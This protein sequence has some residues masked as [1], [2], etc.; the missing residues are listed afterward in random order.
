MPGQNAVYELPLPPAR[1]FIPTEGDQG[2]AQ[3]VLE[4]ILLKN[5]L[6][7]CR[8]RWII[9][10][11]FAA[12]GI[13]T[14]LPGLP[15]LLGFTERV[16]WPFV[17]AATLALGNLAFLAHIGSLVGKAGRNVGRRNLWTQIIFDLIIITVS[18]HLVGS[19][20]THVSFIYLFHVVLSCIFLSRFE[21]F[22]ITMI[23][24]GFF[25][26][27]VVLETLG[28]FPAKSIFADTSV[29]N[30]MA[31]TNLPTLN[32]IS[33]GMILCVVWYL[34]SYLSQMVRQREEDLEKTNELL[35]KAQEERMRFM[36]HTTHE[37]KAP[38]AAIQAN[39][40]LLMKGYCGPLPMDAQDAMERIVNRSRRLAGMIQEMLQLA[41][42]R[43]QTKGPI[44]KQRVE[45]DAVLSAC[46][47]SVEQI[48]QEHHVSI[49]KEVDPAVFYGEEEHVKI[50]FINIL[51]NAVLYSRPGKKVVVQNQK[52]LNR[53]VSIVTIEDQGIGIPAD[54]LPLIFDEYYH[55]DEAVRYNKNSTGLGLA[56]VRHIAEA[57]GIL[58]RVESTLDVGTKFILTF[59]IR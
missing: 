24:C 43:S 51:T 56:I 25:A 23:A 18:V 26:V 57:S 37:L 1:P 5:A 48:A 35:V 49:E 4:S 21:S 7:Y 14:F 38:F 16:T 45:L 52:K 19:V 27:C 29:R 3:P 46:L 11:I 13:F 47:E 40:Q 53:G 58:V 15:S 36:L 44:R 30:F 8:L 9:V 55:T 59:P 12:T 34:A 20:E 10:G 54:K 28:A 39:S 41:N 2:S 33:T 17:V 6:W 42:L 50:L 22:L 31:D 32:V